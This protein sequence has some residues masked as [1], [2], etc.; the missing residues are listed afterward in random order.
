LSN[1]GALFKRRWIGP[2]CFRERLVTR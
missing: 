2:E 1:P